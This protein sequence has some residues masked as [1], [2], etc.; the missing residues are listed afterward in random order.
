MEQS[1]PVK[2]S[3]QVHTPHG[4]VHLPFPEHE[5]GQGVYFEAWAVGEMAAARANDK[6]LI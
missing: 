5:L 2:P 1:A 6:M 4:V 3:K